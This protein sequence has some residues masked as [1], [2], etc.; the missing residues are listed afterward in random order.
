MVF[1]IIIFLLFLFTT[2]PFS[3]IRIGNLEISS[4]DNE[5]ILSCLSGEM[6][7]EH[8]K[9]GLI[10]PE[11][12]MMGVVLQ[13][14][15]KFSSLEDLSKYC[16]ALPSDKYV[17]PGDF[18]KEDGWDSETSYRDYC[19][20]MFAEELG[21]TASI[22]MVSKKEFDWINDLSKAGICE[23]LGRVSNS[24]IKKDLCLLYFINR[25]HPTYS[26]KYCER[27]S[28][29]EKPIRCNITLWEEINSK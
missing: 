1:V 25:Q 2:F 13:T 23:E 9:Y 24:S 14:S 3:N 10:G 20:I 26:T 22:L 15:N 11:G 6:N 5:L 28:I 17:V 16:S 19:F 4:Y 12:C 21:D 7:K 8:E 29:K 27:L 18:E